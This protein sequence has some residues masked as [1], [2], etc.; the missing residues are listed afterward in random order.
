LLLVVDIRA[1]HSGQG[2]IVL[3]GRRK[4]RLQRRRSRQRFLARG[5][6]RCLLS[7]DEPCSAV[8]DTFEGEGGINPELQI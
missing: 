2:V 1:F 5:D 3:A 6:P 4:R 7:C 8:S